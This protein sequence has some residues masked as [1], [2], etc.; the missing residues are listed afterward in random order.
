M[1]RRLA[2]EKL[3][4]ALRQL[5]DA[6]RFKETGRD[7]GPFVHLALTFKGYQALGLAAKA[8]ADPDFQAG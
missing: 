1:L 5:L 6:K 2:N 4:D 8:P 7:G 3:T